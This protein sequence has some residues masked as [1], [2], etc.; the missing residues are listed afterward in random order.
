MVTNA[1]I[2][3]TS[4]IINFRFTRGAQGFHSVISGKI[5]ITQ[6]G[7]P[8]VNRRATLNPLGYLQAIL[9]TI[10]LIFLTVL[11]IPTNTNIFINFLVVFGISM[12]VSGMVY[13]AYKYE[14]RDHLEQLYEEL[15]K[16]RTD[17]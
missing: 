8:I 6:H 3:V 12:M 11:I 16:L 17:G 13:F 9:G 10:G 14:T 2:L 4:R 5:S 15:S 1:I 7:E